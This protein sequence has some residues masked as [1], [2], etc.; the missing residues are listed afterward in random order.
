MEKDLIPDGGLLSVHCVL[1]VFLVE[2]FYMG[3]KVVGRRALLHHDRP[4]VNDLRHLSATAV[5]GLLLWI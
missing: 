3:Q 1:D 5:S 2:L 4:I